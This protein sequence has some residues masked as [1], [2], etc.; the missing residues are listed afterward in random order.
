LKRI[1]VEIV[2][3][4]ERQNNRIRRMFCLPVDGDFAGAVFISLSL[5]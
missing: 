3:S 5:L 2:I 4:I 1:T